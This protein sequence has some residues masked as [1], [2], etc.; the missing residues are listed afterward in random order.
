MLFLP[1]DYILR[2]G[3]YLNLRLVEPI[4]RELK[5]F[6]ESVAA[7]SDGLK[8]KNK[9]TE[10]IRQV[11]LDQKKFRDAYLLYY[12]S[13]NLPKIH[14]PLSEIQKSDFFSQ[15]NHLRVL[16]VGSGTGSILLG[17]AYWLQT[18]T[19]LSAEFTAT[20]YAASSLDALSAFYKTLALPFPLHTQ[21]FNLNH[22]SLSEKKFDL[23]IAGNI[24]NELEPEAES[25]II[26]WLESSLAQDG[27]VIWIEPALMDLSRRLLT[28]RDRLLA[29]GWFLYSP[30][31]T[32][33]PCPAL[34]A[35]TDWCHHDVPWRRP[36]FIRAIDSMTGHIRQSLKFTYVVVSNRDI[37]LSDFIFGRRDFFSDTRVVSERFEEKGRIRIFGCNDRGR[38]TY[39]MNKRDKSD[40]NSEFKKI[41]RYDV[42]QWAGTEEKSS[43]IGIGK[44]T[45]VRI[46]R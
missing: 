20:D 31:F 1:D 38:C 39:S 33:K 9:R 22:A 10:F 26:P 34:M 43:Y 25:R 17:L 27:L 32:T 36:E 5:P 24:L 23:I 8:K 41:E 15:K 7:I 46:M 6:A 2:L 21:V 13:I 18:E 11:Y 12:G 29:E 44:D 14:I 28:F 42:V 37:H 16:D 30:C 45:H 3:D 19:S 40:S 35:E 4:S